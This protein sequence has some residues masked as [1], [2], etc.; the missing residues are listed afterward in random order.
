MSSKKNILIQVTR[1]KNFSIKVRKPFEENVID[2]ISDFSNEIRRSSKKNN[3][4]LMYLS[5]WCSRKKINEL[6]KDYYFRQIRLGRGL[7]F[8]ICPS[9]VPTNFI[10]SFFFWFIKW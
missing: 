1:N 6:K 2:F 4:D 8:H 3:H 7:V 9:N 10:Y 5:L